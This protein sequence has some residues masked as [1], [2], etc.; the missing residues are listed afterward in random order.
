MKSINRSKGYALLLTLGVVL[1]II[2]AAAFDWYSMLALE[3]KYNRQA[4][5]VQSVD[6]IIN[7]YSSYFVHQCNSGVDP[8]PPT[9]LASLQADGWHLF[10]VF[11]PQKASISLSLV[12]PSTVI[13]ST[14][15]GNRRLNQSS[16]V[17]QV[18]MKYR[19]DQNNEYRMFV[20]AL[21][22]TGLK[23]TPN[24]SNHSVLIEDQVINRR[25]AREILDESVFSE[26]TCI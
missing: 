11:N 5:V 13:S 19:A 15:T 14:E 9:T 12:R 23:V 18:T 21:Y 16:T 24:I 25:L 26:R 7:S 4:R 2:A 3:E 17:L 20:D 6:Q 8:I 10:P 22:E 1:S